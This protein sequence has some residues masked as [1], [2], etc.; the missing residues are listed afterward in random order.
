MKQKRS[1]LILVMKIS[2]FSISGNKKEIKSN[3]KVQEVYL[4]DEN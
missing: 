2:N 3:A 4:G 1:K